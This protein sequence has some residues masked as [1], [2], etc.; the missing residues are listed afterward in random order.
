MFM[1]L[2]YELL[3]IIHVQLTGLQAAADGRVLPLVYIYIYKIN[4]GIQAISYDRKQVH[5]GISKTN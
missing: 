5:T 2:A 1:T 4:E 3:V